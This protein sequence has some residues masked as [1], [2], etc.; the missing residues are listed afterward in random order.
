MRWR[1]ALALVLFAIALGDAGPFWPAPQKS[2]ELEGLNALIITDTSKG[3]SVRNPIWLHP[4]VRKW[5]E[6]NIRGFRVVDDSHDNFEFFDAAWTAAY[7]K[8]IADSSGR[9][10]WLLASGNL[11]TS[12]Q[13][14]SK[15]S[16]LI[17]VLEACR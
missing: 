13:L 11:S 1:Y 15:P 7:K 16:D 8:A 12:R 10:P 5:V 6:Q 2:I 9:R 3:S 14:P 4:D 17:D